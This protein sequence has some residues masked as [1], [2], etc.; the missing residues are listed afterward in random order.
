MP[1]HVLCLSTDV[2]AT[3]NILDKLAAGEP[4][5]TAH[6]ELAALRGRLQ[7]AAQY[8]L[9]EQRELD[10]SL[11]FDAGLDAARRHVQT[12]AV[13]LTEDSFEGVPESWLEDER[14][15]CRIVWV[16]ESGDPSVGLPR[17]RGWQLAAEQAGTQLERVVRGDI[18][19]AVVD[20]LPAPV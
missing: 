4:L 12:V 11:S 17:V 18:T 6:A 8:N 13:S 9:D 15:F 20:V 10:K 2:Q 5:E 16:D 19:S 14:P 7:T 3:V 1:H